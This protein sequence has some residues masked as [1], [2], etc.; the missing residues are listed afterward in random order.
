M[1]LTRNQWFAISGVIL[2]AIVTSTTYFTAMFGQ[3]VANE[4][5][6]TA[7]FLNMIAAGVAVVVTGQGAQVRD[8]LA[9][10]GVDS[11]TVNRD[12]NQTLASIAMD[13]T[14]DKIAP[15]VEA[16]AKVSQTAKGN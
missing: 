11:M 12:A 8:V 15:T 2:S 16:E 5:V 9:M 1:S 6:G 14:Q 4:I 3:T 13:K 7:G 10:P